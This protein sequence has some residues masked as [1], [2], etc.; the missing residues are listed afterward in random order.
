MDQKTFTIEGMTCAACVRS[1]EKA[2]LKV[3][4]VSSVS[5]NLVT[6]KMEVAFD[7]TKVSLSDITNSVQKAGYKAILMTEPKQ[8]S[9]EG[10]TCAA[11]VNAVEKTAKKVPGVINAEVNLT[12]EKLRITVDPSLFDQDLLKRKVMIAGYKLQT[13]R[14]LDEHQKKKDQASKIMLIKFILATVFSIPLL[15]V[16]MGHMIG[17][18][19]PM[20]LDP[21]SAPKTFALVQLFLTIPVIIIG[22]RF[23]LIGFKTLFHRNPNMDTLVALGTGAAFVH[24]IY[25]TILILTDQVHMADLYFESAAVIITLILLGKYFET[26]SKGKTSEAIKKLVDLSPKTALVLIQGEPTIVPVEDVL[27]DDLILVKP[28]ERIPVDGIITDG[29]SSIDESM[30]TGE[31]IPV[32]KKIGDPVIG[33]SMNKNGALTIKATK[34]GKDSTLS[35]IIKLVEDA[36]SSKA[37]IAKLADTIS[38]IFV[39]IVLGLAALTFIFWMI[40]G[41]S[42]DFSLQNMIA[43]LVIACPC[44]LGLATPTAIMVGTGKGASNGILIKSGEALEKAHEVNVVVLDKTGT[45]TQGVPEVKQV[46][47]TSD[48]SE[49]AL[50]QIAASL[51]SKSEHPLGEAI[52]RQAT[53]RNYKLK[54]V[55]SFLNHPGFGVEGVIEGKSINIGNLKFVNRL[56]VK[57][58]QLQKLADELS[59]HGNTLIYVVI[60]QKLAGLIAIADTIKPSSK[61]AIQAL[62]SKGIIVYMMTGDHAI[63]AKSIAKEVGIEHVIAEVLP[64][65]KSKEVGKLKDQGYKVAMVGDGINDAPALALADVGIAIGNGTDVAIESADIVLMRNDLMDVSTAIELSKKTITN[66][67]ENLFWAFFYNTLGIPVAMGVLYLFGGPLLDPMLAGAAMSFSSVSVVANALRLKRFKPQRKEEQA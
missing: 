1:V 42:I 54:P 63:T 46:L 66:I 49:E 60:D 51:E 65:D 32:E 28:G 31:S 2:A 55:E 43:V 36:Q 56:K 27:K 45:I 19:L 8:Y 34:V 17:L 50:L 29:L 18:P 10:M 64:E 59:E 39:P 37:P 58:G 62:Q 7:S 67:K 15:Y 13:E 22:Y 23:Y 48:Y 25:S 57:I 24:G 44:A 38:G 3:E 52:V 35:Q 4:G 33:V 53:M 40:K 47:S 14:T 21:H 12:T 6:N 20:W 61:K 30:I 11:C 9:V 5:V 26:I 16:A 41:E